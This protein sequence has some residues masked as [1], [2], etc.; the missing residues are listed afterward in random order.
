M[1]DGGK[2]MAC[3]VEKDDWWSENARESFCVSCFI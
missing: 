2:G 3:G 1:R